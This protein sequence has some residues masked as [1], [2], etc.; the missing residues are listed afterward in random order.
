[1]ATKV[2]VYTYFAAVDVRNHDSIRDERVKTRGL[3]VGLDPADNLQMCN[4]A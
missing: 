3:L 1:M 4:D 2:F